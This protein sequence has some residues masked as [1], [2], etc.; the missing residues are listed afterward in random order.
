[1]GHQDDRP[2]L[3]DER[4]QRVAVE[5]LGRASF[6]TNGTCEAKNWSKL[7]SPAMPVPGHCCAAA[8]AATDCTSPA[9]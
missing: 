1:M 8:P 3:V 9:R 5:R 4:R 7:G 6:C 2:E